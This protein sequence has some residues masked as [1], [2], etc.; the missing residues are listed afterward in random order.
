MSGPAEKAV[1][2]QH[3]NIVDDPGYRQF[4]SGP[5]RAVA[6]RLPGGAR[7]LDFGCGPG[8][9]LADMLEESGYRVALYDL[10]YYPDKSVLERQYEFICLT[11]VI[12]HLGQPEMVLPELWGMLSD[13]GWLVIQ[14]QRVR[15]RDA[16]IRW[17]YPDDP[18]HIAFYSEATFAWLANHLGARQWELTSRDVVVFQ[19]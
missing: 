14:T 5:F 11:E 12:E 15:N 6:D 18:T 2:D 7:G 1:Y 10:Y 9:A 19:K 4:L 3:Q 8:P 16:F 17:R 13:R